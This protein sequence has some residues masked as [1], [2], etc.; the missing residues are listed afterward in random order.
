MQHEMREKARV[1]A[2]ITLLGHFLLSVTNLVLWRSP[3][4]GYG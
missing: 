4:Q 3:S 1:I 2:F